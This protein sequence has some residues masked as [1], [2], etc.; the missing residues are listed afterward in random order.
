M[1]EQPQIY[2]I[3]PGRIDLPKFNATLAQVLDGADIACFRLALGDADADQIARAAD[4]L[5]ETCHR[6]D[7]AIVIE[8]HFRL[9]DALGLDGCHLRNSARNLREVRKLLGADAIIGVHCAASRHDGMSAGEAGADYISFG[10]V[11]ASALGDGQVAG[12]DL[13]QWWS[14]MIEIPV[15]AEGGL[16]AE[17]TAELAPVTDFFAFGAEIWDREDPLIAL[18]RL[19]KSWALEQ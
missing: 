17:L 13:F 2:L 11:C 18:K 6:R 12:H 16:S 7:V 15:V 3:S 9:V 1:H 8:Q 14:E 19:T 5:R 10:P 4:L